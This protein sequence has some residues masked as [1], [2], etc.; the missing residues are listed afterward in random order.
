MGP[1]HFTEIYFIDSTFHRQSF[2]RQYISLTVQPIN[3]TFT[4][5]GSHWTL[6]LTHPVLWSKLVLSTITE[7]VLQVLN[8]TIS[9]TR[10]RVMVGCKSV[11]MDSFTSCI[12]KL[13]IIVGYCYYM[14]L[15]MIMYYSWLWI[16]TISDWWRKLIRVGCLK[17]QAKSSCI[18]KSYLIFCVN[19]LY[20]HWQ[21]LRLTKV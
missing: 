8:D 18:F 14:W 16:I 10:V 12:L 19:F 2:H 5:H 21:Q 11:Q 13:N 17:N 1:V 15:N 6:E 3:E 4:D 9:L 20:A 7:N